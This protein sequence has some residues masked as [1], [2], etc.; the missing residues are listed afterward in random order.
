[1]KSTP[2][3][4]FLAKAFAACTVL[5]TLAYAQTTGG[6]TAPASIT[7]DNLHI[8]MDATK[9][10]YPAD[11]SELLL[12]NG[13]F[14]KPDIE[15]FTAADKPGRP[16]GSGW[17][18]F[19]GAPGWTAIIPEKNGLVELQNEKITQ[20][21]GGGQYCE[22]DSHR[23]GFNHG[24]G[25]DHGI[26]QTVS[27]PRGKYVFIFNYHARRVHMNSSARKFTVVAE[28]GGKKFPLATIEGHVDDQ[29][30]RA[31]MSFDVS[32]G[33]PKLDKIP[34]TLKFD[35]A[36]KPDTYGAFVDSVM[37][38]PAE[39]KE[40]I[41]DQ[42]AGNEANK[43]PTSHYR[44]EPNNPMLM[45]TRTKQDA[46]LAIK[47]NV[48]AG[49]A[50]SVYVGV[51]L[52]GERA[53][54][55]SVPCVP[56]PGKTLLPFTAS[57][58]SK[59]YE[60]VAGYDMNV[61]GKLDPADVSIVFQKTPKTNEDGTPYTVPKGET[62][63]PNF[64]WIDRI[65]VVTEEDF[66][67]ARSI[68]ESYPKYMPPTA[69]KL[70]AAFATGANE[71]TVPPVDDDDDYI[72][73]KTES[74]VLLKPTEKGLSHPL[75]AKWN[76]ANEANT[77]RIV[78]PKTSRLALHVYNSN[79]MKAFYNRILDKQENQ[80]LLRTAATD[81][82]LTANLLVP[83]DDQIS[84]GDTD[85]TSDPHLSLGKCNFSG[86]LEV[87]YRARNGVIEIGKIKCTGQVD[88]LYD[89]A[90]AS[91]V[92][93]SGGA[94]VDLRNAARTQAGYASLTGPPWPDAGRV[95]FTRV[96]IDTV[97]FKWNRKFK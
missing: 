42:I 85:K 1:M 93:G 70:L 24:S 40:V 66:R 37:L 47:M 69:A 25:S 83:L 18:T 53:I 61:N 19:H 56:P 81:D 73:C 67:K 32:G 28:A 16:G 36:D 80:T 50:P 63:D 54:I 58:G 62:G 14:S 52:R 30:H 48:P 71:V 27:L 11:D 76:A 59:A 22:L 92:P 43:L 79:A 35:I 75:G 88:D 72:K 8:N 86:N 26:Q 55:N 9:S 2:S 38:F 78:M 33:E 57:N 34:V 51:R 12:R 6:T 44:R 41:S 3:I 29:W 21:P 46:H 31:S 23:E 5:A 64:D 90:Y 94:F 17:Q 84:F 10:I 39:I 15:K 87:S 82:W 95:F 7:V 68:T 91:G 49:L 77:H 60:I 65:I 96:E 97:W 89:F 20:N 4:P 74:D 45:A 13:N